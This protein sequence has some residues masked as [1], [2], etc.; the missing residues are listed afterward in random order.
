MIYSTEKSFTVLR[1]FVS[2]R[3]YLRKLISGNGTQLTA[4]NE[5]LRKVSVLILGLIGTS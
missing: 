1:R 3:G 4:A 2:L 5:K